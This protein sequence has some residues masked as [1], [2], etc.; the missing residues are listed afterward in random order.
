MRP[1]S[2]SFLN[3]IRGA[4]SAVF[5]ARLVSPGQIGVQPEG[6]YL[7][8]IDDPDAE[9]TTWGE[10]PILDGDVTFDT[11][12]DVN[13]DLDLLTAYDFPLTPDLPGNVYG[14]EVYVERGVQY[15]NGTKEYVGLGYFR[16]NSVEQEDTP[17]GSVRIGGS[18]R[19]SNVVDGDPEQP[20]QFD[21]GASVG[22]VLDFVIGEVNPSV[23]VMGGSIYDWDAYSETINSSHIMN[24]G[25]S[26]RINFVK[27]LVQSYGKIAYFDY[28]GRFVVK[29][30]PDITSDSVF[31][32]NQ[33]QNGIL[34]SMKR[35]LSRDGVYNGVVASGE[36]VGE[37]PPVQGLVHDDVT[38]SPTR[39][40]GPFGKVPRFFSSSFL[41]TVDQCLSAARSLLVQVTGVPYTVSLGSVPNPALEGYDIVRVQYSNKSAGETHILD[42]ITYPLSVDATMNIDTRKQFIY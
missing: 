34:V 26:G 31:T 13:A 3:T 6:I 10:I 17:N 1:V 41:Q 23:T 25:D 11:S 14:D 35:A 29:D 15:G 42:K 5:R 20:I 30:S 38:S 19:M 21:A 37:Q 39:W 22:S 28:A 40:G 12:S 7:Q 4:H 16:I 32:I 18:D 9:P 24:S 27:D 36:P 33:G 8:G 2:D